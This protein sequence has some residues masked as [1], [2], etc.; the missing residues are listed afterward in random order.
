M[1]AALFGPVSPSTTLA[2]AVVQEPY[3]QIP[4]VHRAIATLACGKRLERRTV[5][6]SEDAWKAAWR[7]CKANNISTSKLLESLVIEADKRNIKVK[8]SK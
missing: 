4:G 8:E 6:L 5:F 7:L 1:K 2:A 3:D